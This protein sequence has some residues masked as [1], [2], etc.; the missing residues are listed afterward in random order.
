M[1]PSSPELADEAGSDVRAGQS[2]ADG[3]VDFSAQLLPAP[4]L[5]LRALASA[6]RVGSELWVTGACAST[7]RG[8]EDEI[9]AVLARERRARIARSPVRTLAQARLQ[10]QPAIVNSGA[11]VQLRVEADNRVSAVA[12]RFDYARAAWG[13]LTLRT[14]FGPV[15]EQRVVALALANDGREQ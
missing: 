2:V 9:E 13:P 4:S 7:D 12:S 11:P 10:L 8:F 3:S 6:L 5:N 15:G 14:S 1:M